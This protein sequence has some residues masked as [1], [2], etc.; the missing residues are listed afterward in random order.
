MGGIFWIPIVSKREKYEVP[1]RMNDETKSWRGHEDEIRGKGRKY[2]PL[3]E[4]QGLFLRNR[5]DSKRGN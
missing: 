1:L 5:M 2:G 3:E 4:D